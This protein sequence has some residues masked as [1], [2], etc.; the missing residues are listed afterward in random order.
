MTES[1]A[2]TV[3]VPSPLVCTS[4]QKIL[5]MVRR[6]SL[7]VGPV[8]VVDPQ[9]RVPQQTCAGRYVCS[10]Q[11]HSFL[12]TLTL[13]MEIRHAFKDLL[14]DA[15]GILFRVVALFCHPAGQSVRDES[16]RASRVLDSQ[17]TR[18]CIVPGDASCK[19]EVQLHR[20]RVSQRS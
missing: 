3:V 14:N 18:V 7:R 17:S 8:R 19:L 6:S 1:I 15:A 16:N 11:C 5:T 10:L 2:V 20:C 12:R 4:Q 13:F 9:L